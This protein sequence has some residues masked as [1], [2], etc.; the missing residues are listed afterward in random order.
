MAR[1]GIGVAVLAAGASR[2]F[3][4]TDKL[5]APFRGKR[6]G[7]HVCT[8]LARAVMQPRWVIASRKDHPC[9]AAWN[10][11]GFRV[12]INDRAA[13][14]MGT[15]VALAARLARDAGC[16]ALLIALADTPLV[17]SEHFSALADHVTR[18]GAAGLVA[19][20]SGAARMPPAA[21]GAS[22]FERLA[23]LTGDAGARAILSE[24][25]VVDCPSAWLEDIDTPE[26]LAR[27]S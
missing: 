1:P 3:G 23:S 22:H 11:A 5:E 2:R 17:P 16:E 26:A 14:G 7:E 27:L 13:H 21:F 10:E 24:G 20:R 25:D 15:S 9:K 8:T 19:S 4:D 6:L 12:E 18:L